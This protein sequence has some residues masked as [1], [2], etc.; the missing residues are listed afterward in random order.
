MDEV[1]A[2]GV[3]PVLARILRRPRLVEQVPAALPKAQPVRVV[4]RVFGVDEMIA[5]AMRVIRLRAA[6]LPHPLQERVAPELVLLPFKRLS[7]REPGG[8][9]GGNLLTVLTSRRRAPYSSRIQRAAAS[10]RACISGRISL[11]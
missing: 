7:E 1:G 6:R 2:H 4:Q 3:A 8:F 10:R 9:D 5:G 11:R